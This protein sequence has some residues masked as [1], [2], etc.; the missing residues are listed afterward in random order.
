MHAKCVMLCTLAMHTL[1]GVYAGWGYV[2]DFDVETDSMLSS[3]D[4]APWDGWIGGPFAVDDKTKL[5]MLGSGCLDGC[6]CASVA[7]GMVAAL[8]CLLSVI[9]SWWPG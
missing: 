4:W 6:L 7:G 5:D 8:S 1:I 2:V 9:R 3:Y